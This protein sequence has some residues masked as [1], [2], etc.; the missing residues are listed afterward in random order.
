MGK[1]LKKTLIL[2][3]KLKLHRKKNFKITRTELELN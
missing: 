2:K 3:K 1:Q